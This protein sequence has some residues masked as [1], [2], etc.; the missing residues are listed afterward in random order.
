[1]LLNLHKHRNLQRGEAFV[2]K[3]LVENSEPF[4]SGG[5][6]NSVPRVRA[7]IEHR[8]TSDTRQRPAGFVHQKI[9]CRK[10]PVVA[11]GSGNCSIHSS[12]RDAGKAKRKGVNARQDDE[13]GLE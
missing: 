1:M 13:V 11:V 3:A 10:V 4:T 12:L 7:V 2:A 5:G 6:Q 9:G 8:A